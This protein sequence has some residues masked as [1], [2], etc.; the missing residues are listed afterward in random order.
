MNRNDYEDFDGTEFAQNI[1]SLIQD[2]PI[3]TA[4]LLIG[5]GLLTLYLLTHV[6]RLSAEAVREFTNLANAVKGN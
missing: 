5:G 1:S 3:I 6:F 4:G 2:S